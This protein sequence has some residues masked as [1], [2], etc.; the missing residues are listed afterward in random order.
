MTIQHLIYQTTVTSIKK[1]YTTPLHKN[2]CLGNSSMSTTEISIL[3]H[4]AQ[5]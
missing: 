3:A 2:E 4:T 5:L 1:S